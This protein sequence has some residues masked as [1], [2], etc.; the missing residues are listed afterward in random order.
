MSPT[1]LDLA[2]SILSD[3]E[4]IDTYFQVNGLQ[5]PSFD[6]NKPARIMIQ[7][8][9]ISKAHQRMIN[10]SRELHHL[11]L[12]PAESLRALANVC[13]LLDPG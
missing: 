7:D 12:G 13:R 10:S 11:A 2:R 4:S 1:I 8:Q 9:E 3:A 6:I 5:Q